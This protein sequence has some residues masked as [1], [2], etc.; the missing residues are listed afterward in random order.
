MYELHWLWKIVARLDKPQIGFEII[1]ST[2][3][4]L[5]VYPNGSTSSTTILEKPLNILSFVIRIMQ[6]RSIWKI[7]FENPAGKN[8]MKAA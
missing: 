4:Y 1:H 2:N 3:V 5:E 8:L 6:T 7:H